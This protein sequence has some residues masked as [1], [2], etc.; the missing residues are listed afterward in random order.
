[1][2]VELKEGTLTLNVNHISSIEDNVEDNTQLRVKMSNGDAYRIP[3]SDWIKIRD[4]SHDCD[5]N[6]INLYL[7]DIKNALLRIGD[8]TYDLR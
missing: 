1:M 7:K 5:L 2:L 6:S 8:H 3:T 4:K